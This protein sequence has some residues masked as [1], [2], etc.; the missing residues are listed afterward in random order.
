[1]EQRRKIKQN[2]IY[3]CVIFFLLLPKFD[4]WEGGHLIPLRT[5]CLSPQNFHTRKLGEISVCCKSQLFGRLLVRQLLYKANTNEKTSYTFVTR[6]FRSVIIGVQNCL[7]VF[8]YI[9]ICLQTIRC[10]CFA[11][12]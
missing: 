5:L 3:F 1:M 7:L 11:V 6:D 8:L 9:N 10:A 2:Q 4:F 12:N